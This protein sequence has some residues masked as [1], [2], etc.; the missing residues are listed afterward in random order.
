MSDKDK[1]KDILVL[2]KPSLS[3]RA[4]TEIFEHQ[5]GALNEIREADEAEEQAQKKVLILWYLMSSAAL[6]LSASL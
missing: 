6:T 4:L 1:V 2:R 5:I 3:T